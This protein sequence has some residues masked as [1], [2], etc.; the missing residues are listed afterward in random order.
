MELE[1]SWKRG[2]DQMQAY[3]QRCRDPQRAGR[4]AT[5]GLGCLLDPF[6]VAQEAERPLMQIAAL[7]R[8]GQRSGGSDKKRD[9]Q[10][11]LQ[12]LD[13]LADRGM[14]S[15]RAAAE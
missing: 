9:A 14:A 15:E 6:G 2:R 4:F 10:L 1:K 11:T 7:V 3:R 5:S 12:S 8:E 13:A